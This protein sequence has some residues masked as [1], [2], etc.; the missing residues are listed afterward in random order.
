MLSSSPN[1]LFCHRPNL[2][3]SCYELWKSGQYP[4]Y[5][6]AIYYSDDEEAEE[7]AEG[8]LQSLM[9]F[10]FEPTVIQ[11]LGALRDTNGGMRYDES[12]LNMLQRIDFHLLKYSRQEKSL[13]EKPMFSVKGSLLQIKIIEQILKTWLYDVRVR[14]EEN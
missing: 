11:C 14:I 1:E 12:F 6:Q 13:S 2:L 9:D 3:V 5:V 10:R 4:A 8:I 7:M